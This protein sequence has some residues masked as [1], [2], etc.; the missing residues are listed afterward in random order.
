MLI[1]DDDLKQMCYLGLVKAAR[2]YKEDR[3]I[4]FSTYAYVVIKNEISM[5]LRRTKKKSKDISMETPTSED[6]KLSVG[7]LI[8]AE[9]DIE[10]LVI[11]NDYGQLDKY[12][13]CLNDKEKEIMLLVAEGNTQQ[14]ISQKIGISQSYVSR[15][16]LKAI[17]K[18]RRR[19][20]I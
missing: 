4:A 11:Y 9:T 18:I 14:Q 6:E 19:F 20:K 17:Q 13:E 3:N 12:L 8:P 2:T 1:E 7:D 16:K 15:L 5:E 10:E